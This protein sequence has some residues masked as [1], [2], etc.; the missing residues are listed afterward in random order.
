MV[1]IGI[2]IVVCL[3]VLGII[4][5]FFGD[6]ENASDMDGTGELELRVQDVIETNDENG[7][8]YPA[9]AIQV[10]GHIP[11]PHDACPVVFRLHIFD[12]LQVDLKPVL[13]TIEELQEQQTQVFEWRCDPGPIPFHN[14]V[15][16]WET[17][18]AIP[19]EALVFPARGERR[20]T[21]QL[22]AVA[23]GDVPQFQ[24]GFTDGT[25]GTTYALVQFT[26]SISN[27]DE[28]YEDG[29]ENRRAAMNITP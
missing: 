11:V 3:F 13:C 20:T 12:G 5:H 8:I 26:R 28:G 21:F 2:G 10:K 19:R 17:L 1:E 6:D 9:L 22:C 14:G 7:H 16:N 18:L 4:G 29:A 24:F 27:E 23:P 25:T 15:S